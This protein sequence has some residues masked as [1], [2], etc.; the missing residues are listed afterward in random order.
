MRTTHGSLYRAPVPRA[1]PELQQPHRAS[2]DRESERRPRALLP[3]ELHVRPL[4]LPPRKLLLDVQIQAD[5][6]HRH[7]DRLALRVSPLCGESIDNVLV[8]E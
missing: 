7:S 6:G 1:Q 8:N 3:R 4:D 2:F 5:A